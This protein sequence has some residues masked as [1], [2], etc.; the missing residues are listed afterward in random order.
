[1]TRRGQYAKGAAKREEILAVA[2]DVVAEHGCRKASNREIAARVGL[3]QPGLMHYFGSREE[4]FVELLRARDQRDLPGFL[5]SGRPS[6]EGF[7]TTIQHNTTVPGLVQLYIEFSAEASIGKHPAHEFFVERYAAVRGMLVDA[8]HR[9]QEEGQLGP[10]LDAEAAA[11]TL[12]AAAD[13][14][15][16]QWL[17]DNSLDMVGRLRDLW[18][19]FTLTSRAPVA[20]P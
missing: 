20:I 2:L 17:L 18:N 15:Q 8:V 14:L 6:I 7:F 5:D 9:A 13:G 11:A 12:M 16:Q 3:T 1:M 10:H 4:L 19:G